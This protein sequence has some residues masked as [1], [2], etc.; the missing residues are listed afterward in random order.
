M[1]TKLVQD[2]NTVTYTCT[3]N[4]TSG[5][6]YSLLAGGING[7]NGLP[8]VAAQSGTTGATVTMMAEGVFTLTKVAEANSALT[9]GQRVYF[10]TT[11]GANKVTGVATSADG[12]AGTAWSAAA[13]GGTTVN[14]K[15]LGNSVFDT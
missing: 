11:G 10:R 9:V 2:G 12:T 15:L 4:V 7:T 3:G 8:V 14:V 5:N 1:T 6:L 13:T